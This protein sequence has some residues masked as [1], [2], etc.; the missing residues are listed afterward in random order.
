MVELVTNLMTNIIFILLFPQYFGVD[1]L[2]VW[3][4][5]NNNKE[6][7]YVLFTSFQ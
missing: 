4:A 7:K 6:V 5:V 3:K 1:F 2:M